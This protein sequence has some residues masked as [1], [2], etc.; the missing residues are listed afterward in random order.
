MREDAILFG[1]DR[2]LIGVLTDDGNTDSPG[3]HASTGVLM[4]SSGLDHH[5]GPNCIYVKLARQLATMGFVV[6]RF[7][8]SGIGDSGPRQDKLPAIESVIDETQQAMDCLER[9]RG[10]KQ[11]I[12]LGLCNGATS[13]FR[14]AAVDR[15]IR[16]AVLINALVPETP[17]TGPIRQHTYYWHGALFTLR[18]WKRLLL[19]QS[20]YQTILHSIGLKVRKLLRPNYLQNSEHA[21]II[22]E[23]IKSLQF[24]RE[25]KT[26]LFIIV[27]DDFR[28]DHYLREFIPKEYTSLKNVGLLTVKK[29]E[30]TDH[31]ITPLACQKFLLKIISEWMAK[32]F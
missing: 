10:I 26:Q 23:L 14:I 27:T 16:G 13:A 28:V 5:V 21:R 32:K 11:F 18:S 9:L 29:L 7:S 17:Q 15:R 12:A 8:F 31:A 6:L 3:K 1:R 22:S 20:A 2:S 30:E 4:L 25:K 19:L 24:M